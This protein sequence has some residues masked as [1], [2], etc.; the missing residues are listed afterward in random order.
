MRNRFMPLLSFFL[1]FVFVD[2]SHICAASSPRIVLKEGWQMKSSFLVSTNDYVPLDW[3]SIS[4]PSTVLSAL[5]KNNVYPDMRFGLNAYCIPDSYDTFNQENDLE[6]YSYLPGK[7]NPW[8]DPYW[9]RIQFELSDIKKDEH[10]WLCFQKINYRADIWLNGNKVA[11][12]QNTIGIFQR[13][14]FDVSENVVAG[15][16]T[17]AVKIYPVDH[18][19]KPDAQFDVFGPVRNYQKEIMKDLTMVMTI[20][21]DC[22]PTV[23]DRNMGILQDVYIDFTGPVDVQHPFVVTDLPLPETDKAHLKISAGVK[24]LTQV[25]QQGILCGRILGEN[26]EFQHEVNLA[27][28]ETKE[29]VF[30]P[31]PVMDKPRLWWPVNYGEQPLYDLELTF[32]NDQGISDREITTFGVRELTKKL[33]E[34][35]GLHGMQLHINGQKI[36]C[37]GGYIQP[38]IL[39]D[40]DATRMEHEVRYF[41]EANLNLVYFE[42]IPNPPDA[43]LDACDRYGLL[44]GNCFYG[45]FWM[46][47]GSGYPADLWLA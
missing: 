14:R 45:C 3:Y 17:L 19:A 33:H 26:L 43:F 13:Y 42:D 27:A 40:W 46:P 25:P 21:Y 41:T 32:E 47:P 29:V 11:D 20:G 34:L 7:R 12:Q 5:I 31:L 6:Q 18:P 23:P 44:F 8:K 10:V 22:M 28:G 4:I 30:T 37:R 24:N 15:V 35:D 36:F 9:F 16:N 2:D 38:E 1:I 39:L